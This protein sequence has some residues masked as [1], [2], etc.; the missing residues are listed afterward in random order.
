MVN[1]K[2]K[3]ILSKLNPGESMIKNVI[4][5][6]PIVLKIKSAIKIYMI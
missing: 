1:I 6:T 3:L 5:F 4:S 2:H